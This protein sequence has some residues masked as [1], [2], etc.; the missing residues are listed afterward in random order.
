MRNLPIHPWNYCWNYR[1]GFLLYSLICLDRDSTTLLV[2]F[3][4]SSSRL[5]GF[6]LIWRSYSFIFLFPP[7]LL[8]RILFPFFPPFLLFS[9]SIIS[10]KF[11]GSRILKDS[12]GFTLP[13]D[14]EY[15]AVDGTSWC[16]ALSR[17]AWY[18][19]CREMLQYKRH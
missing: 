5:C 3:P 17:K 19:F 9:H 11:F 7:M 2:T 1:F 6:L 4:F 13:F 8:W 14:R 15:Y 16:K 12:N 18:R 10:F